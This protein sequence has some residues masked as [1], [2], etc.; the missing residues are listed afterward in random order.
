M[1]MPG[2]ERYCD[3]GGFTLVEVL[4]AAGL[5][6][7][8]SIGVAQL[9]AIASVKGRAARAQTSATVLATAKMEQLRALAWGY[10]LTSDAP[11]IERSDFETNL[12]AEPAAAGGPGLSL[13]PA[14]TLTANT[15]FYFEFLDADGR[16]AGS[17]SQPPPSAAFVRR[18]AVL[19]LPGAGSRTLV[20]QV[21]VRPI[22]SE[23]ASSDGDWR[24]R[25]DQDAL[26]TTVRTRRGQ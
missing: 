17:G 18:W 22:A 2:R 11:L 19:P 13:S 1:H 8:A 3:S 21:L 12:S 15:A 9:L 16:W 25:V 23:R 26:L 14:G 10:E 5:L 4:I 20:L 24:A 7:A 6:V